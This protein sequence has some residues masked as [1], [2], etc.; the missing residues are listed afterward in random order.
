MQSDL[1]PLQ[2]VGV[3]E[4]PPERLPI[5]F[6]LGVLQQCLEAKV[7]KVTLT[8]GE[9]FVRHGW[10]ELY[11]AFCQSRIAVSIL[12]NGTRI[13]DDQ[14]ILMARAGHT[15]SISLDG[16]TAEQ[17]DT[18]RRDPGSFQRTV[19]VMR[20]LHEHGVIFTLNTVVHADNVNDVER[21]LEIGQ[22]VGASTIVFVPIT[23]VGRGASAPTQKYFPEN[24]TLWATMNRIRSLSFE[25]AGPRVV[26]ADFHKREQI[27]IGNRYSGATLTSRRAPGLCKAGVFAL[28]IDE[29][30]R[31]YSCLR[32]LQSRIYPIGDL[33]THTLQEVWASLNWEP[34]R[35]SS[36]PMVPC[37]VEHIGNNNPQLIA[38]ASLR[39]QSSAAAPMP[40]ALSSSDS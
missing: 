3:S 14:M 27:E 35:D 18:F 30:G 1:L 9:P 20:R 7:L 28:A 32:G 6:W 38:V 25:T 29:D 10:D 31:V 8:G 16:V 34:F 19:S 11:E 22:D 2:C 39:R 13:R 5:S 17:H 24:A 21:I 37:R 15:L 12:T 40:A 36:Q 23:A 33:T 26:I 4:A